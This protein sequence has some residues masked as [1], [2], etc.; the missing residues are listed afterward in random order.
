MYHVYNGILRNVESQEDAATANCYPTTIQLVVSGIRKLSAIA[1]MPEGGAV[2]RGLAGLALP[3]EFFAA[4]A[5][6]CAG[7]VEASFM[8][9][10]LSEE[11]AR[12]YSGVHEGR[13]AT[14]FRLMLGKTS[15]GA[16]IS[17]LS[18]FAGEKEMLFPP[19]THLQVVGEPVRGDDGVSVVT[20]W[21]TG[22]ILEMR[23]CVESSV[24][25]ARRMSLAILLPAVCWLVA[26]AVCACAR[27]PFLL[28]THWSC[29]CSLPERQN[30]RRGGDGAQRGHEAARL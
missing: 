5:Q 26:C 10:T 20:L 14:I 7:G 29:L 24:S 4:D 28:L 13:E 25:V 2:F 15:L 3:P 12:K 30:R 23:V 21:P 22:D 1:K 27:V 16:D 18:Q 9:T 19:R 8:S 6:G 17:W 11:V